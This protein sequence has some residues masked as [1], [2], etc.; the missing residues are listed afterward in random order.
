MTP[1][2]PLSVLCLCFWQ[3]CGLMKTVL[4]GSTRCKIE[5]DQIEEEMERKNYL[6][7]LLLMQIND[8][9]VGSSF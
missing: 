5:E 7:M 4:H 9:L 3:N 6:I 8:G 2:L 1:S